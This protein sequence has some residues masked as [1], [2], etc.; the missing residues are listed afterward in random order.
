MSCSRPCTS[1]SPAWSESVSGRQSRHW[2][3]FALSPDH[4]CS[5]ARLIPV[6]LVGSR[7]QDHPLSF[8]LLLI[9]MTLSTHPSVCRAASALADVAFQALQH[10]P[11]LSTTRADASACGSSAPL[12]AV[13]GVA[14]VAG[15]PLP[16][17]PEALALLSGL[18]DTTA[19][20][21][22][23][24]TQQAEARLT[25]V[26]V[27]QQCDRLV[28][29]KMLLDQLSAEQKELHESLRRAHLRG[30]LLPLLAPGEESGYHLAPGVVLHR[31][32]GRR[33]WRYSLA[34]QELEA[35][36]K[37]RQVYEQG[38]GQASSSY[39][40]AFWELRIAKA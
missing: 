27:R 37:A 10:L 40:S 11:R 35:Q 7:C 16:G 23:G 13:S 34:V 36:L 20:S 9:A 15:E 38:S 8:L 3:G 25:T 24:T 17:S 2:R 19:Q 28:E 18:E 26:L 4:A 29:V 1:S 31:R 39:G 6:Q 21:I 22:T 14:A 12:Q 32:S 33:Q 5:A 30:A